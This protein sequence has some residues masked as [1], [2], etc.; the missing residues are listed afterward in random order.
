MIGMLA[1]SVLASVVIA[2]LIR[3]RADNG[4]ENLRRM[5]R[6]LGLGFGGLA[7]CMSLI[8]AA[9]EN[10]MQAAVKPLMGLGIAVFICT[11]LAI[12]EHKEL[13]YF[14]KKAF[15]ILWVCLIMTLLS[16]A[17]VLAGFLGR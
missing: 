4:A 1:V 17:G 13:G 7:V 15:Y 11:V 10:G 2:L 8:V 9:V 5:A 16:A 12:R 6:P 14:D 3:L